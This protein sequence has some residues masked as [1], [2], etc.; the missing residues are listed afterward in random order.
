MSKLSRWIVL[1]IIVALIIFVTYMICNL[2]SINAA[3]GLNRAA[4][5]APVV[6]A[7]IMLIIEVAGTIL[8]WQSKD[9]P[10]I[11]VDKPKR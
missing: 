8:I 10:D 6:I 9:I 1:T 7:T 4:E 5:I 2:F 3:G 11:I